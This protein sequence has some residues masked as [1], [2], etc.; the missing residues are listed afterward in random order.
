V[1]SAQTDPL[2]VGLATGDQRAFAA[3]YDRYAERLYRAAVGILGRR[4]DAEDVVQEVFTAVF[5][6]SRKMADVQNLTAYLFT[7]LRRA[8][9]RLAARRADEPRAGEAAIAD[10][11]AKAGPDDRSGI[12]G[13][14]LQKALLALPVEQREVIALKIDGGLTFAEIAYVIGISANTAASRYRY[15]LEKLRGSLKEECGPTNR[16]ATVTRSKPDG[17]SEKRG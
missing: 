9:G 16:A 8:A 12:D 6:S 4:E 1:E 3:L 15:A 10:L 17:T 13:Q 7:V 2:V 14:R 11:T 5:Q